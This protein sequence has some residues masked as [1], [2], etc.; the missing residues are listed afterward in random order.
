MSGLLLFL[1]Y[2]GSSTPIDL[3]PGALGADLNLDAMKLLGRRGHTEFQGSRID[4]EIP[5]ADSGLSMEATVEFVNITEAEDEELG[6]R[7]YVS[8]INGD[9]KN[10][11]INIA[12]GADVNYKSDYDC[13]TA[14]NGAARAG[15]LEC[16]RLLCELGA[17]INR[18]GLSNITPMGEAIGNGYIECIHYLY[19]LGAEVNSTDLHWAAVRGNPECIHLLCKWGADI[20]CENKYGSTSLHYAASDN[21]IECVRILCELGAV[22]DYVNESGE[23]PL[24]IA[25]KFDHTECV[26]ILRDF[27]A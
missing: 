8:A 27:G 6:N 1:S 4:V 18:Q 21:Q 7:L 10:M 26:D 11:K 12:K 25:T 24:S 23:T 2:E 15:E 13:S 5:L 16:V 19:D 3:P 22:I 20:N 9:I 17:D 14:L